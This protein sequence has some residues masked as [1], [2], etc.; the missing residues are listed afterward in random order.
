MIHAGAAAADPAIRAE[1]AAADAMRGGAIARLAQRLVELDS[2]LDPRRVEALLD[3]LTLTPVY[4]QFVARHGW[5][6]D[7][8][9]SW[10]AAALRRDVRDPTQDPGQEAR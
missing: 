7:D 2:T 5:S 6:S 10:L 1:V 3:A 4:E 8:Y 9:E